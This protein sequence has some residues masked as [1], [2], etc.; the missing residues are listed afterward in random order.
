MVPIEVLIAVP[1]VVPISVLQC[2]F[3]WTFLYSD[4][5]PLF[6]NNAFFLTSAMSQ[7]ADVKNHLCAS[8]NTWLCGMIIGE[9]CS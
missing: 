3:I 1:I 8:C 7:P 5:R 6:N 4:S 9:I 2:E